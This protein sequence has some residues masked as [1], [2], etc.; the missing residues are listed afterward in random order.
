MAMKQVAYYLLPIVT[1]SPR[2]G[3]TS[4][5]GQVL[6]RRMIAKCGVLVETSRLE[7]AKY[8]LS[9]TD[10]KD[11]FPNLVYCSITGFDNRPLGNSQDMTSWP[12]GWED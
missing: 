2:L 9:Y 3:P 4:K 10:L 8:G 12:R 6:A 5:E 1:N 11:D 7:L